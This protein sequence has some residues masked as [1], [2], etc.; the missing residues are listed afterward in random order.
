MPMNYESPQIMRRGGLITLV[1]LIFTMHT[2]HAKAVTPAVLIGPDLKP[3]PIRLQAFGGSKVTYFDADRRLQIEP[4]G[5][6]LQ[7]RFAA[8]DTNTIG[9]DAKRDDENQ[10]GKPALVQLTDGQRLAGT[11]KG[12]DASGEVLLFEHALLGEVKIKLDELRSLSFKGAAE[13]TRTPESDELVL[14]NGDVIKG[15]IVALTAKQAEVQPNGS[16]QSI[17]LPM[18]RVVSIRLANPATASAKRSHT[19]W[20]RDGSRLSSKSVDM[21]SDRLA[22]QSTMAGV[23]KQIELKQVARIE[24]ASIAGRLI[25]LTDLPFETVGQGKVFGLA[26]P[27]RRNGNH[28]HLHAP[29]TLRYQLPTRT[30]RFAAIAELDAPTGADKRWADFVVNVRVNGELAG[31]VPISSRTPFQSLNFDADGKTLEIELDPAANGPI[32][33][34]LRLRDAMLFIEAAPN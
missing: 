18:D 4:T 8:P 13:T 17:Q 21:E 30:R 29:I 14:G 22:L 33:D 6:I 7:I 25:D 32:L 26:A 1:V 11:W 9:A 20:L 2:N 16:D 24:L 5:N 31:R 23:E 12:T 27:P 10:S 15:F 34:R 28:L 19:V 3:R